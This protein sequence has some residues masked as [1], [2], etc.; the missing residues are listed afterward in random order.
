MRDDQ[1]TVNL[2]RH[3]RADARQAARQNVTR[4]ELEEQA[5]RNGPSRARRQWRGGERNVVVP[6]PV[7]QAMRDVVTA[8]MPFLDTIEQRH[9]VAP[10]AFELLITSLKKVRDLE[11]LGSSEGEALL[12]LLAIL[13]ATAE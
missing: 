13:D 2:P 6:E 1:P 11:G 12:S 5:R 10:A 9:H 8:V 3:T 7:F 4:R